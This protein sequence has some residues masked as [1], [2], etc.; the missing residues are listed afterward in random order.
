M[1][2]LI[3]YSPPKNAYIFREMIEG[4]KHEDGKLNHKITC[5]FSNFDQVFIEKLVGTKQSSEFFKEY[6]KNT[7]FIVWSFIR[8][9]L[10]KS[11]LYL[12]TMMQGPPTSKQ[13]YLNTPMPNP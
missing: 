7:T 8:L 1:K 13:E 9:F 2:N 4:M 12:D 5:L 10:Y 11:Y 6:N 3:F